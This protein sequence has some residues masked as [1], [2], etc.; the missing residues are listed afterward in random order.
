M[1]QPGPPKHERGSVMPFHPGDRVVHVADTH[2]ETV[3]V[4]LATSASVGGLHRT[5]RD[6]FDGTPDSPLTPTEG[7]V[8]VDWGSYEHWEEPDNLR[9]AN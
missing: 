6:D 7:L 5:L 2:P 4:V 9:S 3:G 8:P 1:T